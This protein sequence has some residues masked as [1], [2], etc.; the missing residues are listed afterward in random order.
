MAVDVK[1]TILFTVK[2]EAVGF[3][4]TLVPI[5]QTSRFHI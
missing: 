3:S 2:M 5:Y 1:I 4:E